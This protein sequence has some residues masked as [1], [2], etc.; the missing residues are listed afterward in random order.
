MF[1]QTILTNLETSLNILE[2]Q[3]DNSVEDV[4]FR[5]NEN[6]ILISSYPVG[7]AAVVS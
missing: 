7:K 1:G 5:R 4:Y 2:C 3:Q 6:L